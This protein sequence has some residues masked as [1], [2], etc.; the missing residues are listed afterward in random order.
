MWL[1]ILRTGLLGSAFSLT[2][3]GAL[4]WNKVPFLISLGTM[5][6]IFVLL[7]LLLLSSNRYVALISAMIAGLEMFA[8]ATS[9]AHANAL[10][11]FGSSAFIS[12]LDI[13][14][15]LGFYL[16]PL[17]IIIGGVLYFIK[18]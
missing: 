16:F 11:E 18:G 3:G 8:S 13:L 2:I 9:S 15:I 1:G 4:L 17:I 5:I 10:S 14:M 6:A 7:L 12:T